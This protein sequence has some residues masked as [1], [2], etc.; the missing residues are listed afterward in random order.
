MRERVAF[1]SGSFDPFTRGH[2]AIVE[3]SL[4]LFDRVVVGVGV[5][6]NKCGLLSAEQRVRLI[7]E[8][9][10]AEP[11]VDVVAYRGLT[12]DEALR[13]GASALVRGVRNTVD[14]ELERT[15][16][17]M[18]RRL[19]G[20]LQTVLLLTPA[21]VADISSSCVRELLAFGRSVEELMPEGVEIRDYL[22][23]K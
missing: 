7:E 11:R 1:F 12:G 6:V 23:K 2:A 9:Y 19:Y 17:S 20:D 10:Q 22:D 14:F 13:I 5:N 15:M 8:L 16:E 18:N 4:R 3:Q 21:D